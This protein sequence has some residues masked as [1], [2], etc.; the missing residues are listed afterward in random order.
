[1]AIMG[2]HGEKWRV[3]MGAIGVECVVG[4]LKVY[5]GKVYAFY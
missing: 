1:M 4:R 3:E 5:K 2:A